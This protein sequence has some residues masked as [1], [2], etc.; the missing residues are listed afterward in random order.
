MVADGIEGFLSWFQRPPPNFHR[1]VAV[2]VVWEGFLVRR[3]ILRYTHGIAI[4]I[5]VAILL[6]AKPKRAMDD[7]HPESTA[8][9]GNS[10]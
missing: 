5:F 4:S 7:Q 10:C 6:L 2:F 3:K 8:T 9:T 1:A